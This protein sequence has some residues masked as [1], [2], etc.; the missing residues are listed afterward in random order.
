RRG[1]AAGECI[2]LRRSECNNGTSGVAPLESEH[3]ATHPGRHANPTKLTGPVSLYFET[4]GIR[5]P[6]SQPIPA[7]SRASLSRPR[8]QPRRVCAIRG[9][10]HMAKTSVAAA[11]MKSVQVPKVGGEF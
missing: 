5:V 7:P 8:W 1:Q 6:A 9:V 4:V 3:H 2:L 11:L 10:D